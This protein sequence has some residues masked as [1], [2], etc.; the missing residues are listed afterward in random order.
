MQGNRGASPGPLAG[1]QSRLGLGARFVVDLA[2][3][4]EKP[5]E[6]A[7]VAP[8]TAPTQARPRILL[9]DDHEDTAKLLGELL[10]DAGYEVSTATSA[11]SALNV[12]LENIDFVVSDIGLPDATGLELIQKLK[13]ARQLKS[14]ALNGYGNEADIRASVEA[15]F[16]AHLTKPVNF[17]PAACNHSQR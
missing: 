4:T 7:A 5:A 3:T 1:N 14:V 16:D 10:T 11:Q 13:T 17:R 2:T 12:D 15:G 6:P 8:Y 9:V